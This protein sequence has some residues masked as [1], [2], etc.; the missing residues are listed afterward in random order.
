MKRAALYT[1]VSTSEQARDGYSLA[2]QEA[3]MREYCSRHDTA[4]I[5]LYTD[6]GISGKNITQRPG[7]QAL[8]TAAA[9]GDFDTVLIW[10]LSRLTR[11]LLD[12]C[13]ICEALD[14]HSVTL[15]SVSESF[16]TVSPGGRLMRNMLGVIAQFDREVIS[17]N[18]K[19]AMTER[20]SLG[21]RTAPYILGY[22]QD[23][24]TWR[25]LP[26]EA[27]RVRDI[28]NWYLQHQSIDAVKELCDE[29]EYA[30]KK[31]ARFTRN[32]IHRILTN[33]TYC[34]YCLFAGE[35]YVGLHKAIIAPE[36]YNRVQ[37]IL[38]EKPD[39]RKRKL[40]RYIAELPIDNTDV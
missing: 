3:V 20:A 11:S 6:E 30:G 16:E 23:G 9:R 38:T 19:L 14:K 37:R 17:E 26:D 13:M 36:M 22:A 27:S 1:R 2:A 24:D 39:G 29:N 15:I 34:G 28:Y 18:V 35:I 8:L 33:P 5:G 40:P 10:K 12:L 7:L 31:G 4:P 25:I 21:K 32:S